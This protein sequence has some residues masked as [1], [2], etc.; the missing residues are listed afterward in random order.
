[1]Q[2]G[3]SVCLCALLSPA[4]IYLFKVNNGNTRILYGICL[5]LI[6]KDFIVN[7]EQIP[8][9]SLMFSLLTLNN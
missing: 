3:N 9:I 4:S 5:K 7:F 2:T 1:M 6:I 8:D